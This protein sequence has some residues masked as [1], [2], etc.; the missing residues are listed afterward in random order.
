M[1]SQLTCYNTQNIQFS[2]KI[3]MYTKKQ[4][5]MAYSQK[6]NRNCSSGSTY[7]RLKRQRF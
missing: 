7:I 6:M 5:C 1:I 2:T 4:E 3:V